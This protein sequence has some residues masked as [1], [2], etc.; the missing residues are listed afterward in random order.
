MKEIVEEFRL[1]EG[2]QDGTTLGPLIKPDAVDF[3]SLLA[4]FQAPSTSNDAQRRSLV[5]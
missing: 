2:L 5:T 3:V 1:G 4:P